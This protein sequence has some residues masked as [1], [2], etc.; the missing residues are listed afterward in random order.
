MGHSFT[1]VWIHAVWSTKN[2]Q[3]FIDTEVE[4]R[5]YRV[6]ADEFASAKCDLRIINGM[7]DHV[8]CLFQLDGNIFFNSFRGAILLAELKRELDIAE[9]RNGGSKR[10]RRHVFQSK[11]NRGG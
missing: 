6:I 1:K 8:H 5:I 9:I 11:M 7:P 10:I 3:P 4:A 2:R